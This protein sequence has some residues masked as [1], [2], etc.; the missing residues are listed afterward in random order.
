MKSP[1]DDTRP[2]KD[3][4]VPPYPSAYTPPEK[5]WY[6]DWRVFALLVGAFVLFGFAYQCSG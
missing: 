5:K 4:R 2:G 6:K 3:N 1:T